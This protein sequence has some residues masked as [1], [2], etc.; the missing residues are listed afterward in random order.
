MGRGSHDDWL[1]NLKGVV[2]IS[3]LYSVS[4]IH[5]KT[6]EFLFSL[7]RSKLV[8]IKTLVSILY[9]LR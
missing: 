4:H 7:F 5:E 3:N 2:S 1:V 6:A 9:S 8:T